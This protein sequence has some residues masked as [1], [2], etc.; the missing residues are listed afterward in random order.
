MDRGRRRRVAVAVAA[1]VLARRNGS[2]STSSRSCS[3]PSPPFP[4]PPPPPPPPPGSPGRIPGRGKSVLLPVSLCGYARR[5]AALTE[6]AAA[7]AAPAASPPPSP[8]SRGGRGAGAAPGSGSGRG[9]RSGAAAAGAADGRCG[10]GAGAA[11]GSAAAGTAA[12]ARGL[13]RPRRGDHAP[14]WLAPLRVPSSLAAREAGFGA[15]PGAGGANHGRPSGRGWRVGE[16]G[17]PRQGTR[18]C[19]PG[20]RDPGQPRARPGPECRRVC[21]CV[22]PSAAPA[23]PTPRGGSRLARLAAAP[24]RCAARG[25][26]YWAPASGPRRPR[27]G[28]RG[29][30][31]LPGCSQHLRKLAE[32]FENEKSNRLSASALPRTLQPRKGAGCSNL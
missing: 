31:E 32:K 17:R 30:G 2:R 28:G 19:S 26:G 16:A 29:R 12:A 14:F 23:P 15:Q 8:R 25:P 11:A 21:R 4:S 24:G 6:A 18:R 5:G 7:A 10:A 22:C 9:L 1:R 3:P 20:P 13:A 27:V